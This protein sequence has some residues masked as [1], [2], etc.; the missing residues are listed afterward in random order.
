MKLICVCAVLMA[1]GSLWAGDFT[2]LSKGED[3]KLRLASYNIHY[4]SVF[5]Q[6]DG[7]WDSTRPN[8]VKKFERVAKAMDADIWAL[9][10]VFHSGIEFKVRTPE[11]IRAHMNSVTDVDWHISHDYEYDPGTVQKGGR[12]LL[13]RY[14]ILWSDSVNGRTHATLIDLPESLSDQDLLVVNVHFVVASTGQAT[15]SAGAAE[16]INDVVA[17]KI[18]QVPADVMIMLCGDFNSREQNNGGYKNVA[19]NTPLTNIRPSHLGWEESNRYYTSGGVSFVGTTEE[20]IAAG[21]YQPEAIHRKTIDYMFWKSSALEV[22]HAHIFNTL[23]MDQGTLDTYGLQRFD[24]AIQTKIDEGNR[25]YINCDHFPFFADL[26]GP[27]E[28]GTLSTNPVPIFNSTPVETAEDGKTYAYAAT[29]YDLEEED[30]SWVGVQI[31]AWLNFDT[32]TG[33]LSGVPSNSDI[34]IHEVQ[35]GLDDGT[36]RTDQLFK[37]IVAEATGPVSNL[38]ENASFETGNANEWELSSSSETTV[39]D[40]A[41]SHESYSLKFSKVDVSGTVAPA[42]QVLMVQPNTD[43]KFSV[44]MNYPEN[45]TSGSMTARL[46]VGGE[47]LKVTV[48]SSTGGWREEE[49]LFNS[50]DHKS[51]TLDIYCDGGFLGTAFADNFALRSQG[52]NS[53]SG[54]AVWAN[55]YGIGSEGE[56]AD[57]DGRIN[58]YEYAFSGD[59]LVPFDTGFGPVLTREGTSFALRHLRRIGDE[60]LVYRLQTSTDLVSA[61]WIYMEV[62][63]EIDALNGSFDEVTHRVSNGESPLFMRLVVE[64]LP[65]QGN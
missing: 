10:E 26:V 60:D 38:I 21:G 5:P 28:G 43:Y 15:Q 24:V 29:G 40:D 59:P 16:F 6:E 52:G 3:V 64:N 47:K 53:M 55:G 62:A 48:S 11:S 7:G 33:V 56:D 9:Q 17:G 13:S 14:P 44:D 65:A 19:N 23:I 58:L 49:I 4:G 54:Y 25:G 50:G 41:A 20:E 31:P 12:Y 35:L 39:T 27:G 45:G 18:N 63:P 36:D 22:K 30:L 57:G 37:I 8:R 46:T 34:G 42:R 2:S 61:N 32:D 1:A 51:I